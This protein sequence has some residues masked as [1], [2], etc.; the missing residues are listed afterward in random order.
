MASTGSAILLTLRFVAAVGMFAFGLYLA[1]EAATGWY[2]SYSSGAGGADVQAILYTAAA[3]FVGRLTWRLLKWDPDRHSL[4]PSPIQRTKDALDRAREIAAVP[5]PEPEDVP[6]PES[7]GTIESN[8]DGLHIEFPRT[9]SVIGAGSMIL[10]AVII[11]GVLTGGSVTAGSL[12]ILLPLAALFVVWPL[13]LS[14]RARY[15]RCCLEASEAGLVICRGWGEELPCREI[16]RDEIDFL[17]PR[18]VTSQGSEMF[19]EIAA[20]LRSGERVVLGENVPGLAVADT[21]VRRI[22]TALGL[23]PEQVFTTARS[24]R[25]QIGPLRDVLGKTGI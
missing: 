19:F 6:L 24:I 4:L 8:A 25:R 2:R 22:G 15:L 18:P 20:V 7:A 1:F 11:G 17:E 9:K 5:I 10:L 16:A 14:L 3:L 21:L 23:H 13:Y 12:A